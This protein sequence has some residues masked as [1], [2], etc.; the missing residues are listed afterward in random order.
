MQTHWA[1][2]AATAV[3]LLLS[4]MGGA[5]ATWDRFGWWVPASVRY[6]NDTINPHAARLKDLQIE[7]AEG[8]RDVVEESIF[9]W[10]DTISKEHDDDKRLL[11]RQ[12]V[13][14]LEQTK[15]RL[16]DQID[17]LRK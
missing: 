14:E 5:A 9:K 4:A 2:K 12:R 7:Q 6:V 16:D 13:R 15:R 3:F 11:Y 1:I 10:N 17:T 8:K